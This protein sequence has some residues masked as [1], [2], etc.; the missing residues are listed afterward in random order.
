MK[1]LGECYAC[2]MRQAL[3]AARLVTDDEAFHL[4]VLSEAAAVMAR[5]RSDMTPPE[6]G[7]EIYGMVRELSGNPDPFAAQKRE[8]ND[9]VAR[10]LPWLR[11]EVS[12]SADPLL[13]AVRLAIA[14]NAV[15]PGAR[16][17]FD[18]Q[19][20]ITEALAGEDGLEAYPPL[21]ERLGSARRVMVIADNC[22]E[23]IFDRVLVETLLESYDLQ[24]TLAVRGA[25]IINDVTM[26]EARQVGMDSLCE[27]ISSGME[28]PGTVP[29]RATVEFAE[30]FEAADVVLSKGQGNWETL[31]DC[32]REVFFLFQ[33]K[34]P[35]VARYVGCREG[36]P[37][38]LA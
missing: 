30:R 9:A 7:E 28:M 14:G 31:E 25:P 16:E 19:R 2:A 15:D 33:A 13:T 21:V 1:L 20:S 8:Q 4:R 32:G 38:L 6:A 35:G 24:V 36:Q 26:V 27:V 18:L 3:S 34:C 22:G 29:G 10:L 11:G 23:L 5:A 37:L 17:S 12:Q